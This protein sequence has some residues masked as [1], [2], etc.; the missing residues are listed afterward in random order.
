METIICRN[1]QVCNLCPDSYSCIGVI[2][3]KD[4]KLLHVHTLSENFIEKR[5]RQTGKTTDLIRQAFEFY[6]KGKNVCIVTI[7]ED[8]KYHIIRNFKLHFVQRGRF[9]IVQARE[10]G[11]WAVRNSGFHIFADELTPK[12]LEEYIFPNMDS[13]HFEKGYYS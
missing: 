9:Y 5:S 4:C 12:Q 13:H 3:P 1:R 6:N 7:T 2:P 11:Q 8:M 10:F